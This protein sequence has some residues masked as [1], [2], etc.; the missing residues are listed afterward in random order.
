MLSACPPHACPPSACLLAALQDEGLCR[1]H[2]LRLVA[3]STTCSIGTLLGEVSPMEA[4]QEGDAMAASAGAA[5]PTLQDLPAA[6]AAASPAVHALA[7]AD[8]V[9][10]PAAA[11]PP[12]PAAAAPADGVAGSLSAA[13]SAAAL[14]ASAAA[15]SVYSAAAPLAAPIASNISAFTSSVTSSSPVQSMATQLQSA[16][17]AGHSTAVATVAT[18]SAA[19]EATWSRDRGAARAAARECASP[20]EWFV[21]DDGAAGVRYFVI[22]GSDNL[23][24]WRVNLTFDPVTFEDPGL[25]VKAHRGVYETAQILYDRFLPLVREHVA[26]APATAR[27]AFAGHSLGGSLGTLLMLMYVR[28]GVLPPSALAPVYTFGAPAVLCEGG[29]GGCAPGGAAAGGGVLGRMGLPQG[30]VRNVMMH[31]DIVPRAFACDYSLVADLLKRVGESFREH[32]CLVEGSRAVMFN[33]VGRIMMLQ[34]GDAASFVARRGEG[35][36]PLLPP[37]AGLYALRAPTALGG[38]AAQV[39]ADVRA[40]G[41]AVKAAVAPGAEAFGPAP[42]SV[43]EALWELMNNPHPLDTLADPAAYGDRGAISRFHNPDNY[44]RAV[45][46]ALRARGAPWRR[47]VANAKAAGLGGYRPALGPLPEAAAAGREGA[48]VAVAPAPRAGGKA[49]LPPARFAAPRRA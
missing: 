46:G 49:H 47:L 38:V 43:Q 16:A 8:P 39:R 35:L 33:P 28:R 1:R 17:A 4:M 32:S 45:G 10:A 20:T 11:E 15:G 24:H 3:S 37:A 22:Q 44:T 31:L 19:L 5:F 14:A 18:V 48:A 21:A 27:V 42:A 29:A 36:H 23:D 2:G 6:A 41:A 30:A 9:A 26:A 13:A 12:A 7:L 40:V 25:G 34:P